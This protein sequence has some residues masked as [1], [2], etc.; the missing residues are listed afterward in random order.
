MPL[1]TDSL[2]DSLS[3]VS[4]KSREEYRHIVFGPDTLPVTQTASLRRA[5]TF[6]VR[7]SPDVNGLLTEIVRGRHLFVG[8]VDSDGQFEAGYGLVCPAD[9][10][11][12]M[13]RVNTSSSAVNDPGQR[14]LMHHQHLW[15]TPI[16]AVQRYPNDPSSLNLKLRMQWSLDNRQEFKT[17]RKFS[18]YFP[19]LIEV[20]PGI[21]WQ[22]GQATTFRNIYRTTLFSPRMY[23]RSWGIEYVQVFQSTDR[24]PREVFRDPRRPRYFSLNR[25]R[26]SLVLQNSENLFISRSVPFGY[27]RLTSDLGDLVRLVNQVLVERHKPTGEFRWQLEFVYRRYR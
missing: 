15:L 21:T 1:P 19:M 25:P 3:V 20:E 26:P 23:S 18:P 11:P 8:S 6:V 12:F 13:I 7:T 14:A 24:I 9:S 17:S 4:K 22:S 10:V 16:V 5:T 27:L 2:D